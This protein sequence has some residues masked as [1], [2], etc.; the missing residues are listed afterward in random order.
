MKKSM[1]AGWLSALLS[2]IAIQG[3]SQNSLYLSG[4]AV[5]KITKGT[6]VFI[7]NMALKPA[8]DWNIKAL[9][10]VSRDVTATGLA[11]DTYLQRVYHFLKTQDAYNGDISIYYKDV[12]LNGL[13]ENNLVLNIYDGTSWTPHFTNITQDVINNFVTVSGLSNVAINELTLTNYSALPVSLS[14][15]IVDDIHCVA[16]LSWTTASEQ[17][18]K[19]FEVQ[20]STDAINFITIGTVPSSGNSNSEKQY[21]YKTNLKNPNN[22]FRLRMVDLDGKSKYSAVVNVSGN[23]SSTIITIFPNPVENIINIAGLSGENKLIVLNA[24]GKLL[25]VQNTTNSV[26]KVDVNNLPSGTYMIQVL[27][28]QNLLKTIK[29]IK[30]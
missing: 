16:H 14:N 1:I 5:F 21:S 26:E 4:G 20:M 8:A 13:D 12:E 30:K 22:Y 19:D 28:G 24:A 7:D 23:C 29:I 15:F 11:P 25:I 27:K 10:S 2:S 9:S 18:S 6:T 17:N 3:F